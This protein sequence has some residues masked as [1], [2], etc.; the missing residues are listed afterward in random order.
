ML[1]RRV[2]PVPRL[3]VGEQIL[4]L[5]TR[6]DRQGEEL[7]GALGLA[8]KMA[9]EATDAHTGKRGLRAPRLGDLGRADQWCDRP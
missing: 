5:R 2:Q 1:D 9:G 8:D 3:D 6:R 7:D 4:P